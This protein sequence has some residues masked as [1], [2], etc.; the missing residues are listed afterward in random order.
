M[1]R[2]IDSRCTSK[3]CPQCLLGLASTL[4]GGL[5]F[6]RPFL[7][8][9]ALVI[10]I[11]NIFP[12]TKFSNKCRVNVPRNSQAFL[13][14]N[15]YTFR[16]FWILCHALSSM[17]ANSSMHILRLCYPAIN[18]LLIRPPPDVNICFRKIMYV[19]LHCLRRQKGVHMQNGGRTGIFYHHKGLFIRTT[20][21][22]E[23]GTNERPTRWMS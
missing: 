4:L 3:A 1:M 2:K 8:L 15:I 21:T 6:G 12:V 22:Q 17:H 11:F 13:P 18:L 7:Q 23:R 19:L 10:K 20:I 16:Q 14:A 9:I 5:A